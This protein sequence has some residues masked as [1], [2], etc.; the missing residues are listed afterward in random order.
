MGSSGP[1]I[2]AKLAQARSVLMKIPGVLSVGYGF[3][4]RAHSVT[5]ERSWIIFVREKKPPSAIA[6]SELI[7]PELFGIP[8]DV[9]GAARVRRLS[10]LTLDKFDILVGGCVISNLKKYLATGDTNGDDIGTLGFFGTLN[11]STERD[12]IVLLGN[13]HVIAANGAARLDPFFQPKLTGTPPFLTIAKKEDMHPIGV[14]E[15]L[16]KLGDY[17]YHY[18]GD[19][20]LAPGAQKKNYHIDCATVKVSTSFSSWCHTNCGTKFAN[21]IHNLSQAIPGGSSAVEGI[22]RVTNNTIASLPAG[23]D[24]KV[25]KV[26][27]KTGWTVGKLSIAEADLPNIDDP[28]SPYNTVMVIDDLGPNC[29]GGNQPF[30]AEGDSGAVIVNS[31][32]KIIGQLIGVLQLNPPVY[33][34]CHIHPTIDFLGITMVSTANSTGASGGA[35]SSEIGLAIDNNS[36]DV[37]RAMTFREEILNSVRGRLYR[38]LVEKHLH[39]VSYLVNRVRPVTVAWHRLHGPDF[40]GHVLHASSHAGYI[41]PRDIGG[42]DRNDALA[43]ILDVL[44]THGSAALREGIAQHREPLH[45]LMNEVD[46][47]ETLARRL[48]VGENGPQSEIERVS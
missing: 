19:P 15:N 29:D 36:G 38:T 26:G 6:D 30:A 7:P 43:R 13:Q 2:D 4:R 37:E 21:V 46:D 14:I 17:P 48:H 31:D 20:P 44:S 28:A 42:I 40:L 32:R 33:L 8:T 12:N 10:C 18:D 16:G 22:A 27:Y 23:Q 25:F 34:A 3:K 11:N 24:Y 9:I 5:Q 47:I 1:E 39:E 35:T 45:S 41:V